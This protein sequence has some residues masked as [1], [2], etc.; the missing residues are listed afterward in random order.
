[1]GLKKLDISQC[2]IRDEG[3]ISLAHALKDCGLETLI[4]SRN[5]ITVKGIQVLGEV[6]MEGSTSLK[7]LDVSVNRIENGGIEALAK[8]LPNTVLE[9]INLDSTG[10]TNE[11]VLS[12]CK[13][14]KGK[15]IKLQ[16]VLLGNNNLTDVIVT[17]LVEIES[18]EKISLTGTELTN[19]AMEDFAPILKLNSKFQMLDVRNNQKITDEGFQYFLNSIQT[20]P[21]FDQLLS[22]DTGISAKMR[23]NVENKLEILRGDVARLL[24]VVCS[25]RLPRLGCKSLLRALPNELIRKLKDF[26]P[27]N[28][29]KKN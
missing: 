11:G 29:I 2:L 20:H 26:L 16:C 8:A 7:V 1:F 14:M 25:I 22:S 27:I 17:P 19:K 23:K 4:V 15:R 18:L 9:T 21:S 28:E 5:E 3:M 24:C 13:A 10:I 6:L 12:W